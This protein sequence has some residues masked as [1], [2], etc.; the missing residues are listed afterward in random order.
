MPQSERWETARFFCL[1]F[2]Y[3]AATFGTPK[4]QNPA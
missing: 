4:G 3:P 2:H 1:H